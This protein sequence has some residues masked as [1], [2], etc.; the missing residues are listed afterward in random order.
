MINTRTIYNN[1]NNYTG[2]TTIK[3]GLKN[4]ARIVTAP[5]SHFSN[6]MQLANV[7]SLQQ[8]IIEHFRCQ[9]QS[10]FYK[11]NTVSSFFENFLNDWFL[12]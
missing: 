4:N 12:V 10:P 8:M 2:P 5:F 7:P 11:K 3:S 6:Q 1:F 9:N